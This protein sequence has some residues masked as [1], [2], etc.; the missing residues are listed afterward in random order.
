MEKM[1]VKKYLGPTSRQWFDF[2]AI[3]EMK[4]TDELL[5]FSNSNGTVE[6]S[7]LGSP[8]SVIKITD[9]PKAHTGSGVGVVSRVKV[10]KITNGDDVK[11]I[12]TWQIVFDDKERT[13]FTVE[14]SGHSKLQVVQTSAQWLV[15]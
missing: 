14:N 4:S 1:N 9:K 2:G 15:K 13:T 6:L 7:F 11:V 3:D 10:E 5:S 12:S 8:G